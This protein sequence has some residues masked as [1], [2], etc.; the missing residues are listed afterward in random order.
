MIAVNAA[1]VMA[2]AEVV[3]RFALL[4]PQLKGKRAYQI[5]SK[6]VSATVSGARE[7]R[8]NQGQP[9]DSGETGSARQ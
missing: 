4:I 1:M 8:R 7:R 6:F 5:C 3:S 2:R 9:A